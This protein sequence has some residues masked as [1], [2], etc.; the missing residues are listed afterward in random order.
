[1]IPFILNRLSILTVSLYQMLCVGNKE[2]KRYLT[3][4]QTA[5]SDQSD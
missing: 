3:I 2:I 1:M 5:W 4:N